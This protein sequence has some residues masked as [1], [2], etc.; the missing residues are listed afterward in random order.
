MEASS[1]GSTTWPPPNTSEPARTIAS[2]SATAWL[3]VASRSTGRE[4]SSVAS[5]TRL[6]IASLRPMG[7][8]SASSSGPTDREKSQVPASAAA[9]IGSSWPAT[10]PRTIAAM[11]A[12]AA[13]PS[14]RTSGAR[15]LR[16]ASSA[17]STTAT[18]ASSSPCS[19]PAL[20]GSDEAS[21]RPSAVI[22]TADGSVNPSQATTPPS[23]PARKAPIAIPS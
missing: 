7:K 15:A 19:H 12:T 23:L 8:R 14:R 20:A 4:A 22:T 10:P 9:R 16:I 13:I 1:N 5:S 3:E 11:A 21:P 17:V 6:A 18:A 2:T